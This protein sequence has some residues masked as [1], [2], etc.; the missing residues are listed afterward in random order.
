MVSGVGDFNV[1][2]DCPEWIGINRNDSEN[3]F[4]LTV[5][6]ITEALKSREGT[7]VIELAD[8]PEGETPVRRV[9]KISQDGNNFILDGYG[10]DENVG[11]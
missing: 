7:V 1:Y 3:T 10:D 6:A 8:I 2:T 9:V 5:K 4:S 11:H